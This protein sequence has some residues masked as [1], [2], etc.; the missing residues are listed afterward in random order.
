M[1]AAEKSWTVVH[2]PWVQLAPSIVQ[3]WVQLPQCFAS[4]SDDSQ[5]VAGLLSHSAKPC[6]QVTLPP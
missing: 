5:T 2:R 6:G 1:S 4:F 3:S